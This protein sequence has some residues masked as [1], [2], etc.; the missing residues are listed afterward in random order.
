MF[1][2]VEGVFTVLLLGVIVNSIS[3]SNKT[4]VRK[5]QVKA[6]F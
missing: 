2:C 3:A 4:L 1:K 6:K 5:F